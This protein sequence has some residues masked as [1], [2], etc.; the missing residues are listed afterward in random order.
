M[1]IKSKPDPK[2]TIDTGCGVLGIELGSTRIKAV[3]I[4]QN[5][6]AIAAGNHN[7]ENSRINGIWTYPLE[8]VQTGLQSC[9][10]DL[11][12][13]IM[14]R[15]GI[16]LTKIKAMG[17]SGMMHGYLPFDTGDKQLCPFRTWRNNITQ[18]ASE[19]L[20]KHLA[21]NIPQRFSI[22]H[23]YQAILN[24]EPH[25]MEIA[26]LTTLAG[27]VHHK[28]TGENILASSPKSKPP[29]N[30]QAASQKQ[31]P[32]TLTPQ[33]NWKPAPPSAPPK[34]TPAQEWS[35]QTPLPPAQAMS[36][37]EHQH[38]PCLYWKKNF[39]KYTKT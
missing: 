10:A 13:N 15:Y 27:Y 14:E 35:P 12:K 6:K 4:D 22:A 16:K 32:S 7:W 24:E 39:K 38:S 19:F 21:Y 30:R 33:A 25:V 23:L 37:Q 36:P 34:A 1:D 29:E 17:I 26:R 8:E 3:L 9:Y 11:K 20:T 2:S 28:L 18:N 31:E 5:H